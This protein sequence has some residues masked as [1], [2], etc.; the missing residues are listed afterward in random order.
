MLTNPQNPA[1]H[2]VQLRDRV[3]QAATR[4][5]R[6]PKGITLIGVAKRQ[7]LLRL[8]A[9]VAAGLGDIGENYLQEAERHRT[10]LGND[11]LCWHF[12]GSLQANKTRVVAEHFDWVHSLDRPRVAERLSAQRPHQAAP[13]QVC[14]QLHL[15]DEASKSGCRADDLASLAD[16]VAGLPRLKLRGL[17]CLPPEETEPAR[18]RAWFAMLREQLAALNGRGH[19]LDVLSMGMSGD[20]EQAI[21][22]GATHLRIGSALFGPRDTPAPHTTMSNS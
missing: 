17:M 21:A 8:R 1:S 3:A 14:L 19:A 16:I 15:G 10:D 11:K 5:G 9:A 22:E 13:L 2:L 18:Q 6:S 12:I 7:P 4:A 20:F